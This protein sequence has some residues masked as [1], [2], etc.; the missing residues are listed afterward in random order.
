MKRF[1]RTPQ[2]LAIMKFLAENASHP[3]AEEIYTA[4]SGQFPTLSLATVYN[5]LEA[6]KERGDIVEIG[7]DFD[8]KRFDPVVKPHHH[9][10]CIRCKKILDIPAKFNP[11]LTEDERRGFRVIRSQVEFHGLCPECQ[12]RRK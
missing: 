7:P 4:L 9:L 2:R 11:T 10:V 1:R 12:G 3:S 6:L 8:K 5:T